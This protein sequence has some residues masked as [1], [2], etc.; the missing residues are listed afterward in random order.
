MCCGVVQ[1]AVHEAQRL[2]SVSDLD[3]EV[4]DVRVVQQSFQSGSVD[5]RIFGN[6]LVVMLTRSSY[7]QVHCG[8]RVPEKRAIQALVGQRLSSCLRMN[9]WLVRLLA[10]DCALGL[11]R[12]QFDTL[13]RSSSCSP[14]QKAA[15]YGDFFSHKIRQMH[16]DGGSAHLIGVDV[17]HLATLAKLH[18]DVEVSD[19]A[20]DRSACAFLIPD[21]TGGKSITTTRCFRH[22]LALR[23]DA[24]VWYLTGMSVFTN[25]IDRVLH[26]GRSMGIP[27]IMYVVTC[28][29]FAELH[30]RAGA[31]AVFA[32]DYPPLDMYGLTFVRYSQ[33]SED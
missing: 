29:H 7:G 20:A 24:R 31:R 27:V 30:L 19:L 32:Q 1:R 9:L 2:V 13:W 10:A 33:R 21:V 16:L 25:T 23:K 22:R 14:A 26:E 8:A 28:P 12:Q 11:Q 17:G 18:T 6:T 15:E 4:V 5:Q 3:E